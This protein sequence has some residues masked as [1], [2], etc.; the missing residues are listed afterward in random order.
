MVTEQ[1][2]YVIEFN[3]NVNQ[4]QAE[5]IIK[6]WKEYELNMKDVAITLSA[7]EDNS[8]RLPSQTQMETFGKQLEDKYDWIVDRAV[9]IWTFGAEAE[10]M[11]N[12]LVDMTK[13]TQ[14]LDE[15]NNPLR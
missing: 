10:C 1:G 15:I 12:C 4:L 2:Q 7:L 8:I 9:K 11:A 6:D 5:I 14:S 13:G 3:K